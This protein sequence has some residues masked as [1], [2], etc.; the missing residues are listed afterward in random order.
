[1]ELKVEKGSVCLGIGARKS[2]LRDDLYKRLKMETVDN[3]YGRI[4]SQH[5]FQ[6][7]TL[8]VF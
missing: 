1:M 5:S 2:T 3:G 7:R 4:M 6:L 8:M